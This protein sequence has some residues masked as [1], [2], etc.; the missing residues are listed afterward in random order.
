M[1]CPNMLLLTMKLALILFTIMITIEVSNSSETSDVVS[2]DIDIEGNYAELKFT[3]KRTQPS[4]DLFLAQSRVPGLGRGVFAGK[5]FSPP[6]VVE[7][8]PSLHLSKTISPNGHIWNYA[9]KTE[10]EEHDSVVLG[11]GSLF[12]HR[13]PRQISYYWDGSENEASH[14]PREAYSTG[15]N[16]IQSAVMNITEGEEI[17]VNYGESWLVDRGIAYDEAAMASNTAYTIDELKTVGHCLT[18]VFVNK[19]VLPK[20]GK[21][22]FAKIA[23]KAGEIVTISPVAV[24]P[25][26]EVEAASDNST[27]LINFCIISEGSDV[28]LFPFGLAGMV[29]HGGR[30][31]NMR[32]MSRSNGDK[33]LF[34]H[35]IEAPADMYPEHWKTSCI[36]ES[37]ARHLQE[38]REVALAIFE[39]QKRPQPNRTE[40]KLEEEKAR[41]RKHEDIPINKKLGLARAPKG[42]FVYYNFVCGVCVRVVSFPGEERFGLHGRLFV[43]VAGVAHKLMISPRMGRC[44][45]VQTINVVMGWSC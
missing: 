30:E 16:F 12:N 3:S 9:W 1:A 2:Y 33:P 13:S 40:A 19:S 17:F 43:S 22:L 20:A 5:K 34:R 27:L 15:P 35:G 24:L 10:D 28:A 36:G 25:R 21:G 26:H 18:D 8:S 11:P 44:D 38:L 23:Y 39:A 4:C 42:G 7:E 37:C 6:V 41:T 32:V 14:F 29:N 45:G 31:S